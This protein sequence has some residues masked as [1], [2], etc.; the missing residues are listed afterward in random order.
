MAACGGA[1]VNVAAKPAPPA[2]VTKYK[3]TLPG[4]TAAGPIDLIQSVLYFAPG[5]ASAVHKHPTSFLATVLEGQLTLQT[6]AGDQLS[7]PGDVIHE[8]LNQPVQ[9][10]NMGSVQAMTVVAYPVSHGAKPTLAVAGAAAPAIPNKTL[11]SFTL[12]SPSITGAYSLVQQELVFAPGAQT[13]KHRHGGPGVITVIQ[14]E[15][16][17]NRD[18]TET[19]YRMGDSF[20]ETPGQT[21]QAFN[22]GSVELIVAATYLLPD[23]VQLTTNL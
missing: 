5:G 12:D 23:G 21:L 8:P 7:S 2:P 13:A 17:L 22:R 16:T 15:V 14:G 19:T 20:T 9:A 1:A 10:V 11:Y 4:Q 3:N 6:L 18:G